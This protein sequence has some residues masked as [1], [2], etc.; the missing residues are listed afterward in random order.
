MERPRFVYDKRVVGTE[1]PQNDWVPLER[2]LAK[3][4][5]RALAAEHVGIPITDETLARCHENSGSSSTAAADAGAPPA[6]DDGPEQME[7]EQHGEHEE[8]TG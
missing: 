2:L 1:P 5:G 6:S 7:L 4:V 8:P 3:F